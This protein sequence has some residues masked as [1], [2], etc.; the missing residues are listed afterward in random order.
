[1]EVMSVRLGDGKVLKAMKSWLQNADNG[2]DII[3]GRQSGSNE[4]APG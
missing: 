3:K 2:K 4:C 1:M